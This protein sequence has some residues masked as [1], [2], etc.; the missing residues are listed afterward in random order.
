MK[1]LPLTTIP[2]HNVGAFRQLHALH[3]G[4]FQAETAFPGKKSFFKK[5]SQSFMCTNDQNVL[6]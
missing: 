2:H 1:C 6:N 5:F 3:S 4:T